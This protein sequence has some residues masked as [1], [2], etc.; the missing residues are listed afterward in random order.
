MCSKN[1]GQR[2]WSDRKGARWWAGRNSEPG[3]IALKGWDVRAVS[4]LSLYLRSST[5]RLW[6][7]AASVEWNWNSD[8][9]AE[10]TDVFGNGN[11]GKGTVLGDLP[12]VCVSVSVCVGVGVFRGGCWW[13]RGGVWGRGGL[14]LHASGWNCYLSFLGQSGLGLQPFLKELTRHERIELF[15]SFFLGAVAGGGVV[16]F[17]VVVGCR[18][19]LV[20]GIAPVVPRTKR[21]RA[22]TFSQ[23]AHTTR[24]D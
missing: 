6:L 22:A 2:K 20:A 8:W 13:W 1:L 10:K 9:C 11:V 21:T 24:K 12:C 19:T 16:S 17:G 3:V 5:P 15:A 23:R 14:P 18:F 7:A 4:R